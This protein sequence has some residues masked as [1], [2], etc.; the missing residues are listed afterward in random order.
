MKRIFTIGHSTQGFDFFLSLLERHN[1]NCIVDVRSTPYSQYATQY[2]QEILSCNLKRNGIYYL[3]MGE[4]FGARR[5]DSRLYTSE[6]FLD[7]DK[8]SKTTVFKKGIERVASGIDKGYNVAFMCTEKEPIDCHRTILVGHEFFRLGFEILNIL[9]NG[10]LLSQRGI[11]AQ[12]LD[13]YF[14]DRR[15]GS[16]FDEPRNENDLLT[17]AYRFRNRDIGYRIHVREE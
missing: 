2:N 14:P 8:V 1:I 10:Q 4:E 6:G 11:E 13:L 3:F 9:S 17:E 7:F 15:Q 16:L 12:L 5:R